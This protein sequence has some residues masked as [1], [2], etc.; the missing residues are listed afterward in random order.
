MRCGSREKGDQNASEGD[1]IREAMHHQSTKDYASSPLSEIHIAL[2]RDNSKWYGVRE[3]NIGVD[4]SGAAEKVIF[5]V[6]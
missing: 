1:N 4:G 6:S 3:N 2:M 5:G